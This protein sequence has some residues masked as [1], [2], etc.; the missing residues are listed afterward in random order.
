MA[1]IGTAGAEVLIPLAAVIGI[2]FAVFQWYV[3]AKVP[4]PSHDGED[5]GAAQKGRSGHEENAEDGVDYRQVEARCAEIQHAISIGATSFLFTEYRYVH[6]DVKFCFPKYFGCHLCRDE[7]NTLY[8]NSIL[9]LV[10]FL[11]IYVG[12]FF[13]LHGD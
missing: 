12:V 6:L 10:L 4:V 7:R 13:R 11:A 5:G 2:A 9:F 8:D 1:V 3:V